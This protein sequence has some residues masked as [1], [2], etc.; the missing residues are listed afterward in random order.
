MWSIKD[1]LATYIISYVAL[2]FIATFNC[3][4]VFKTFDIVFTQ[5]QIAYH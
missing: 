1:C 3:F 5:L 2:V 4:V